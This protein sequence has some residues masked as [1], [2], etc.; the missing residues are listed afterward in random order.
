[1]QRAKNTRKEPRL[2][3]EVEAAVRVKDSDRTVRVTTVNASRRSV[4]LELKGSVQLVV[5]DPVLCEFDISDQEQNLLPCWGSGNV[6]RVE[7]RCVAVEFKS[8]FFV[9]AETVA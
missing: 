5:G 9:K 7:G 2:A 8:A 3:I 4:L 1:V 6:V